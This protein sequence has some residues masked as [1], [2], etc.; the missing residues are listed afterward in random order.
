MGHGHKV[1]LFLFPIFL[2]CSEISLG[3]D[4]FLTSENIKKYAGKNLG[5][6]TNQTAISKDGSLTID[7]LLKEPS[8]KVKAI[9]APEH[10]FFGNYHAAES[11]KKDIYRGIT[12]YSLH[13][14][15]RRPTKEMLKNIDVLIYDIQDIGVRSYTYISTLFYC[16]EEAAKLGIEV[17]VLDRPNPMGGSLVDGPMLEEKFRSFIGYVNIPYCHGMTV[18]ELALYFN[19][20][21]GIGC[22]LSS[23]LMNNWKRDSIFADTH[24]LWVPTSPNIPESDTPF[25]CATTGLIGELGIVNIGIGTSFPF[26]VI[27]APWID[28]IKFSHT[29]NS[30][31]LKGVIFTPFYFTPKFGSLKDTLCSGVKIHITDHLSYK[32]IKTANMILGILKSLYPIHLQKKIAALKESNISLFNKA[33]GSDKYLSILSNEAFPA[34][35]LMEAAEKQTPAFNLIKNKYKLYQ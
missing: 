6:I 29:L 2:F 18:C 12:V 23:F 16:L 15:T 1:F 33:Y 22:K 4:S 21:Y 10:G 32:P 19:K 17:A 11:I 27:G 30:Q 26:K 28:A 5:V 31:G 34:Y 8:L 9:F 3:I 20:E 13:G 7:R 35:K 14:K 25:Y 24:L